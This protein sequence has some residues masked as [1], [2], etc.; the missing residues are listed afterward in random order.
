[1]KRIL[2]LAIISLFSFSAIAQSPAGRESKTIVADVLARMPTQNVKDYNQMM[3][4]LV[5]SGEQG[6]L[7]LTGMIAAPGKGDNTAVDFALGGLAYYVT[8]PGKDAA[9]SMVTS[10]LIKALDAAKDREI[11]AFL[12]RMIQ[13]TSTDDAIPTLTKY[14]L[15]SDL[16]EESVR[17]LAYINSKNSIAAII[18]VAPKVADKSIVAQVAGERKITPLTPL[19]IEWFSV[20]DPKLHKA[21]THALAELASVEGLTL[22]A[23]E[24]AACN[25]G[26][27]DYESTN[28]FTKA[29]AAVP[30]ETSKKYVGTISKTGVNASVRKQAMAINLLNN[31]TKSTKTVVAAL[32]DNDRKYRNDVL[33]LTDLYD[34]KAV[35]AAI[36]PKF[37]KL[38]DNAKTDVINWYKNEGIDAVDIVSPYVFEVAVAESPNATDK[39]DLRKAAMRYLIA[40]NTPKSVN[41][42]IKALSSDNK[43]VLADATDALLWCKLADFSGENMEIVNGATKNGKLA[44]LNLLSERNISSLMPIVVSNIVS[45]DKELQEA[46]FKALTVT[47]KVSDIPMLYDFLDKASESNVGYVQ[48]AL[49]EKL[50]MLKKEEALKSIESNIT[51]GIKE[52]K[53]ALYT[54]VPTKEAVAILSKAAQTETG[55]AKKAAIEALIS[56]PNTDA[57]DVIYDIICDKSQSA[58]NANA[59]KSSLKLIASSKMTD[60]Q[61]FIMLRRVMDVTT[62]AQ[63]QTSILDA[64]GRLNSLNALLYVAPYMDNSKTAQH[65]AF[66]AMSIALKDVKYERYGKNVEDILNKFTSIRTGSEAGY[67]KQSV[68]DYMDKA[69]KGEVGFVSIFNGKDLSGWKGLVKN[70][71]ARAKMSEK[72]LA[73]AQVVAD[74][75]MNGGWKAENGVLIFTGKGNNLCTEKKYGD[76]EMYVDW[77]I[78]KDGDA[79]IYLRGTPQV[80]IWDTCR[81]DVGAEVGSGGLYNNTTNISKPLV[82][83]DNK[84]GEWNTFYIKMVGERVTVYLNGQKVVDNVILENYW[85]RNLP[86][87]L[88]EQLELQA[89]G[90]QVY[91]RDVFVKELPKVEPLQLSA[92]EAKEGF[93]YLFDG[94]SMNQWTGNTKDYVAENGAITLNPKNGGGGNL[95]TKKEY[96]NFVLRFEFKL[97]PAANNG[98]GIR[99]PMTG[100]AAYEGME[101]QI[102]DNEHQVYKDLKPYQ[103]HGSVYGVIPSKRGFLKPVGEWNCEEVI[104]NGDQITVKINGETILDGNIR[105]ASQGGTKTADG[106]Q[107]PGLL[108]KTGH[109][110][111]LGHGAVV[112]FKNI[113]VKELPAPKKK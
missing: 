100:D 71:I 97:T 73:A 74:E 82:V 41:A 80:Q 106:K 67:E 75:E 9:R 60:A 27:N 15:S 18:E 25:Y 113:R 89:H 43:E 7:Q 54:Y 20:N 40:T 33:S 45:T 77:K 21:T 61:K 22:L 95:Y 3:E 16:Y 29:L 11:K 38:S 98:L 36:A 58:V 85:N 101:L 111:F 88:E 57:L 14:A 62:D 83:A 99:T 26:Y 19:I 84:I 81:R 92:E 37:A 30:Y 91:Y 35:A 55:D 28:A 17:A 56:W 48:K 93:Q 69:P 50:K 46:A 23:K 112:S 10:S 86:I 65:A 66:A 2:L 59:V 31:P 104:A 49:G 109:I 44:I 78:E 53:Y 13:I 24:A 79:G 6:I 47:S 42:V 110:G 1:M 105:E 68:K 96:D 52:R 12:I 107:H 51:K 103:Y 87:F 34:K 72:E 102:L 4:D 8:T 108:N 90:T 32:S 70:P 5:S 64:M 63:L 76:F 39:G 94:V